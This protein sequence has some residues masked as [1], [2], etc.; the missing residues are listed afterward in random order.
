[1]STF[2]WICSCGHVNEPEFTACI[3]CGKSK[4]DSH[5]SSPES[6]SIKTSQL[7]GDKKTSSVNVEN[8]AKWNERKQQDAMSELGGISWKTPL[9]KEQPVLQQQEELPP[10]AFFQIVEALTKGNGDQIS[11][12][13]DILLKHHPKQ[14]ISPLLQIASGK[15]TKDES[16]RNTAIWLLGMMGDRSIAQEL[17]K[18]KQSNIG[19]LDYQS[20]IALGDI[21]DPIAV[22][23]LLSDQKSLDIIKKSL[24]LQAL[25]KI[26]DP[27]VME[28][29]V[30][31]TGTDLFIDEVSD[32]PRI[33]Q[34][35]FGSVISLIKMESNV[36]AYKRKTVRYMPLVVN[37]AIT[38]DMII[39]MDMP[40]EIKKAW[41]YR[42]R[43]WVV[44]NICN[45]SN[46]FPLLAQAWPRANNRT[47]QLLIA[48]PGMLLDE[49]RKDGWKRHVI[50]AS[51]RGNRIEKVIAYDAFARLGEYELAAPGL[52]D[53]DPAVAIA[54][55][56]SIFSFFAE[57]LFPSALRLASSTSV[58][59]RCGLSPSVMALSIVYEDPRA[60]QV[61]NAL[62]TDT[63][64]EVK[65]VAKYFQEYFAEQKSQ[66]LSNQQVETH[67]G[68]DPSTQPLKKESPKW[69]F[70][71]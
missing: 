35:W 46:S 5:R 33:G 58:D 27:S 44:A 59:I 21:G 23:E 48:L 1:M 22:S 66:I 18:I 15:S 42:L 50:E 54:T 40:A 20:I 16:R 55:A 67:V 37:Q 24:A 43:M 6:Q 45:Y 69:S 49:Q 65:D 53:N 71:P 41:T 19:S 11:W 10:S 56:A 38:L 39:G 13:V 70:S 62:L 30:M 26:G 63:N 28:K 12:A 57:P 8:K 51:Q 3:L 47:K 7:Q 60:I 61:A 25:A 52:Q 29:I 34:G 17:L 31:A 36:Q 9:R 32:G 4:D 14:A 2:S 68:T 64:D